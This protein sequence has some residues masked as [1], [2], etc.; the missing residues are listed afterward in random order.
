MLLINAL[1][2]VSM[3]GAGGAMLAAGFVTLKGRKHRNEPLAPLQMIKGGLLYA[4][5]S[6]LF[7]ALAICEVI[8]NH[9]SAALLLTGATTLPLSM[10]IAF[11]TLGVSRTRKSRKAADL[12]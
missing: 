11:L 3:A 10:S 4:T 7:F 9:P 5:A 8:R 1:M 6:A 12:S 2:A